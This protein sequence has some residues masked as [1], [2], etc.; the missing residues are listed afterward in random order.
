MTRIMVFGTFDGIHEGHRDLFRQARALGPEPYLIVSVARDGVVESM[1]GVCARR[2]EDARQKSLHHESGVDEVVLG[3]REGYLPHIIAARPDIIALGYDQAGM[4]VDLLEEALMGAG[5]Q[6]RIVRLAPFRPD[7]YKSSKVYGTRSKALGVD[8]GS[9]R[10]GIAVSDEDGTIAFPHETIP[11]GKDAA[12]RVAQIAAGQKV[13]RIIVGDT[14]TLE[15]FDN[16]V[17]EEADTFIRTLAE[18][19]SVPVIRQSEA[20]ATAEALRFA[21]KGKEHDDAA[22]AAIILQRYLDTAQ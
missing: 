10:I 8:Y 16:V 1:K 22:A 2:S 14:R 6:V 19:S 12:A 5:A 11:A 9:A 13:R 15:G 3:D 21:P 4:Y 7:I 20:F 17:T 18:A